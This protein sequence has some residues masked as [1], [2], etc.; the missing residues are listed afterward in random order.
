[1]GWHM[2]D[3]PPGF[4]DRPWARAGFVARR[5]KLRLSATK[6]AEFVARQAKLRLQATKK[7]E[8]VARQAKLRLQATKKG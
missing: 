8:F 4:E 5:A 1:M 6:K 7:A 3:K 2:D